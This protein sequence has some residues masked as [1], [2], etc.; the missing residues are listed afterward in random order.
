M[1]YERE[2]SDIENYADDTAPCACVSDIDTVVSELQQH[3]VSS[4]RGLKAIT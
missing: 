1:F 4:L 3:P 2:D